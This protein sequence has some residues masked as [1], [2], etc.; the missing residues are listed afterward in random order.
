VTPGK[1]PEAGH[2]PRAS[3]DPGESLT[4]A[5]TPGRKAAAGFAEPVDEPVAELVAEPVDELVAQPVAEPTTTAERREGRGRALGLLCAAQLFIGEEILVYTALAALA[6]VAVVVLTG[7]LGTSTYHIGIM[8]SWL[9][10]PAAG[11]GGNR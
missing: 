1:Q 7:L 2:D 10:P 8:L 5:K 6:L 9:L 11:P 4:A 3:V